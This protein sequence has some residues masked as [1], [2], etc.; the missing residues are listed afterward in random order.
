M[1]KLLRFNGACSRDEAVHEW[2]AA[3]PQ[4]L[5]A[6]ARHWF[7]LMRQC[8]DDVLELYHD[9]CPVV[10]VG[11]VPFAYVNTFRHHINVGFFQGAGL[12]DPERLLLGDGKSMRHVRL[13]PDTIID[14][15]ALGDLIT[16]SYT[17]IRARLER[18]E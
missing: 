6:V 7:I 13:E 1:A 14:T 8:G 2:L 18:H 9:G 11:D 16:M 4:T 10:C 5:R 17:D 15:A 3:E 12:D